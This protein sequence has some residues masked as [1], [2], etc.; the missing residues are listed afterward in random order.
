MNNAM[1]YRR[2]NEIS[3]ADN[4]HYV[5]LSRFELNLQ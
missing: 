3:Y 2:G 4:L 5:M 1:I